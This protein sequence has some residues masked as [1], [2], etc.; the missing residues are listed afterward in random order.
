MRIFT[1]PE[2]LSAQCREWRAA[3]DDISLV[4]TMGYYHAG[5][6]RLMRRAR[7]LAKR[8]IVSL[9]VNPTQFGPGE[10]L[11]AYPRDFER[12]RAIAERQGA[13]ALFAPTPKD[14]Y[15]TN[16]STWVEVPELARGLCGATRPTHFRGV[17]T[18]VLKL[19]LATG[20][21][22]AVFGQK[23]WQQQAIIRRM[24]RDLNVPTRVETVPTEREPDGLA[25]SSRNVYLS[26]E[27]RQIA[28]NIRKGLELA[29]SLVAEGETEATK[30]LASVR[31]YWKA[32]LPGAGI[33]YISLVH[34]EDLREL[35]RI[36]DAGLLACAVKLGKAR[37]IDNILLQRRQYA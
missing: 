1:D 9:F 21:D 14:F 16:H 35:E 7:D 33:D 30:I 2:E 5:H 8:M 4:P 34:P 31:E 26:P 10:D 29:A 6:E 20:A 32:N 11:E 12:D 22:V 3:G 37:L 28:P 17:C 15:Y 36:D 13:D 27:E 18:V 24:A 25:M 23:D 19:F